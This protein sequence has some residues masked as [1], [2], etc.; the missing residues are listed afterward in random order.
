MSK[1]V[2]ERIPE[3][4]LSRLSTI[5]D[6]E[7]QRDTYAKIVEQDMGKDQASKFV[8]Q[9]KKIPKDEQDAL[10]TSGIPVEVV[11]DSRDGYSIEIPKDE[12]DTVK[13]AVSVGKKKTAEILTKPIIEERGKHRRNLHAH[14]KLVDMLEDMFCPWCGEPAVTHLRWLCHEDETIEEA[15]M[16]AKENYTDAS[17]REEIDPRFMKKK[18][19]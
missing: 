19:K 1:P 7:L 4:V 6:P 18:K 9:I 3:R 10:L 5:A 12:I 8:S 2:D 15:K 17:Q 16:Q 11:G 14:S 13:K